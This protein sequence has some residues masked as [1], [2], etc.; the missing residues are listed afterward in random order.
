M[1]VEVDDTIEAE[2]RLA[3]IVGQ[4]DPDTLEQF[5]LQ[6]PADDL[7]ML[8]RVMANHH[9]AGWRSDPLSMACHLD[10]RLSAWPYLQLLSDA[11]VRA[12]DSVAANPIVRGH[13]DP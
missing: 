8:E 4:A 2:K 13:T 11:W 9:A 6:L 1:S 7:A 3:A 12:I 5:A 10:D